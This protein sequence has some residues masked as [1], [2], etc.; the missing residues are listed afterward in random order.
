MKK[1]NL[2]KRAN[3][4]EELRSFLGEQFSRAISGREEKT[5]RYRQSYQYFL[6]NYPPKKEYEESSYV[7]PVVRKAVEAIKPSLMNIFTE[8]EKKAVTFR[9]SALVP[10]PM[11]AM[12][13]EAINNI[14]LRDNDGYSIIERAITEALVTGDVFLKYYVE[15]NIIEEEVVLDGMSS[16]EFAPIFVEYPDT[17]ESELE[18]VEEREG[19]MYGKITLKRIDSPVRVE[20]VPFG[21]VFISGYTENMEDVRYMCH[22]LSRSVGEM[23]EAGFDYDDVITAQT[24]DLDM[25][26][27]DN[28]ILINSGAHT[29]TR[30]DNLNTYDPMERTV[31]IYEH[32]VYTSFFDKKKRPKLYK[33]LST[34][35]KI[36]EIVETE[37]MPFV[38]GVIE[39]IP[40]SFWGV[41]YYDKF[42]KAQNTLT[43][44]H[45]LTEQNALLT[46]YQRW[47]I[48][49]HS[50]DRPSLLA[51][52]RPGAIVVEKIAGAV[53][54]LPA[55]EL[56]AN[57]QTITS[58]VT[59]DYKEDAVS[60][61]GI[62]VTGA[63]MSATAAAITANSADMKD[64]VIARVL[65]YTL[66]RPLFKG[67]YDI[68]RSED[69]KIGEI[70]GQ[71]DPE[72]GAMSP[73]TPITG[74][75]LPKSIEFQIDINTS[76]DDGI[77][78][79]QL[80]QL[81]NTF[82]QWS[83]VQSPMLTPTTMTKIA[84]KVTGLGAQEIAEYFSIP[85]PSEEEM[86]MQQKQMQDQAEMTEL[87]KDLLRAQVGNA[88]A[89]TAKTEQE[90]VE[91]IVDGE[92]KRKNDASKVLIEMEKVDLKKRELE[93]EMETGQSI[94]ISK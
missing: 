78:A 57:T 53:R 15:D 8:N 22:R 1:I 66:F 59:N 12:V 79:N 37:C 64:K 39:R 67:I 87:Q 48:T 26:Y 40:G 90:M 19:L 76:N 75:S 18:K 41:S 23:V 47:L 35:T 84:E 7:V 69:L 49:E 3:E 93:F 50:V 88:A 16:D 34:S 36:L 11:A 29:N 2:N 42:G 94:Q 55:P 70:P 72:S 4:V 85:Q 10:T 60:A 80:I 65:A 73:P 46:T 43:Q 24:A 58:N 77:L 5:Y 14:F 17:E 89:I 81:G 30:Q 61:V 20:F 83:Q 86:M 9:P 44:F 25:N 82:A 45:R 92:T 28:S 52:T 21:D 68:I 71:Q 74:T 31:F 91:M 54:P 13:D 56:T 38:H 6:G 51:S 32:Y 33:V 62:D 27:L 63:N